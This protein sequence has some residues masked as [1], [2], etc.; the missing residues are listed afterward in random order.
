MRWYE[1]PR[2][3][4]RRPTLSGVQLKVGW[5]SLGTLSNYHSKAIP[6]LEL[7]TALC[8]TMRADKALSK[9]GPQAVKEHQR[10][11]CGHGPA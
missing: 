1:T 3:A 10:T 4:K 8:Y 2:N 5:L 11:G 7:Y 9:I 6:Y